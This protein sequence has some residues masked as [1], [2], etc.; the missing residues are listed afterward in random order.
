M[1]VERLRSA[2]RLPHFER[3]RRDAILPRELEAALHEGV[4]DAFAS[5]ALGDGDFVDVH[6]VEKP[7]GEDIADDCGAAPRDEVQPRLAVDLA[8]EEFATPRRR[9]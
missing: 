2:I 9:E 4:S 1:F 7:H 8:L 3:D 5:L 6:L